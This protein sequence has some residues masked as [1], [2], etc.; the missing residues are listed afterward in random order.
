MSHRPIT[1]GLALLAPLLLLLALGDAANSDPALC[2]DDMD[3]ADVL[4]V[5]GCWNQAAGA[6]G[7]PARLDTDG[8]KTI[9]TLDLSAVAEQWG[10]SR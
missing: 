3:A 8:N 7:C 10:W 2:D 5:A 1:L 6:A 4:R 9:T